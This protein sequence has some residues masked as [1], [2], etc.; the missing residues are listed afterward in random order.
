MRALDPCLSV[1]LGEGISVFSSHYPINCCQIFSD[2]R[3]RVREFCPKLAKI[4][5]S[6]NLSVVTCIE[7]VW[8]FYF[9][10]WKLRCFQYSFGADV[11]TWAPMKRRACA[12]KIPIL[13]YFLEKL[14]FTRLEMADRLLIFYMS[15]SL[16]VKRIIASPRGAQ[17]VM[18]LLL[19]LQNSATYS[20]WW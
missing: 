20:S 19:Q 14:N 3:T 5:P 7:T 6:R 13:D 18:L 16:F 17:V 9:R 8:I 12:I 15:H 11:M 1:N 10:L 2:I 4:M